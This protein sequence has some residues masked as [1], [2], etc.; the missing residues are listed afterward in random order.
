MKADGKTTT[1]QSI[2][3][4]AETLFLDNGFALTSTTMIAKK[5]GCNQALVHYYF[6]TKEKLFEKLFEKKFRA[7]A[8]SILQAGEDNMPFEEKLKKKIETHFDMLM[9][10]PKVPFLFFNELLTNPKRLL[11]LKEKI[12]DVP[13]SIIQQFQKELEIEIKNGRIRDITALDLMITVI[14]LNVALFI[15]GPVYKSVMDLSEDEFREMLESRKR[16]NVKVI[17]NSLRP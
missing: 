2:I 4:A 17:L 3:E 9:A 6:R 12:S 10:N 15:V 13:K 7:L 8:S 11:R 5:A 1:E 16:E 14:S